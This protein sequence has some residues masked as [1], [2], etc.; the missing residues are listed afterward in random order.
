MDQLKTNKI[1]IL[2]CFLYYNLQKSLLIF[3]VITKFYLKIQSMLKCPQSFYLF[4]LLFFK[5][6]QM[7]LLVVLQ[8]N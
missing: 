1:L 4:I 8:L 6:Y 7:I 2:E 5:E 3:Y